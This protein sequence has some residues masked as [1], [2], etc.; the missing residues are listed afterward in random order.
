MGENK[1][2]TEP[3]AAGGHK[4]I[5]AK[6]HG[7]R[8]L[9]TGTGSRTMCSPTFHLLLCYIFIPRV[10]SA[11]R[12]MLSKISFCNSNPQVHPVFHRSILIFISAL[13]H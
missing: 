8:G 3:Q 12:F 11:F 4:G 2:T 9:P 1:N 13:H 7:V 10:S 6:L 5:P